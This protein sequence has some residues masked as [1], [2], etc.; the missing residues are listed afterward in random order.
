M[1]QELNRLHCDKDHAVV[2]KAAGLSTHGRGRHHLSALLTR[3]TELP[4]GSKPLHRLDHGT[5][6]PILVAWNSEVFEAFQAQWP[7]ITKTYHSWVSGNQLP[8]AGQCGFPI[9][10]K[11]C[12]SKFRVLGIRN[13]AVHGQASL[14]EWAIET[15]RTHQIRRHASAMGHPVV[16]DTVY[17]TPPIYTGAGLH[18]TCTQLDY[19]HPISGE[20]LAV[21]VRPAKKMK[22]VVPGA[23]TPFVTSK[24]TKLFEG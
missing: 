16:G 22:R 6:G 23:F 12:R 24:F 3:S 10:G 7:F 13:W 15:G 1:N 9:D 17:G 11:P 2:L 4:P 5:R 8:Y 21:Q 19:R 14:V 18:L 20:A